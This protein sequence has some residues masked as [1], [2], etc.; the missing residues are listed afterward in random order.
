MKKLFFITG[1]MIMTIQTTTAKLNIPKY[2]NLNYK[3]EHLIPRYID[4]N[5][6]KVY[7][8]SDKTLPIVRITLFI[9]TGKVYEPSDK[10]GIGTLFFEMLREGGSVKFK[11]T[12]IEK[13]LEYLG[14]EINTVINNEDASI[15]MYCH[16]K[17]FDEVFEIFSD[18]IINP[19]FEEEKFNLKKQEI[20]E[21]IKR[22]N[23]DPS[24]QVTREALRMFFGIE[25]PY[26]RR[27]EI[28]TV[29]KITINDLKNF[30]KDFFTS[31]NIIISASGDFDEN[32]MYNKISSSFSKIP[33][34][35]PNIVEIDEP[36]IQSG[37]KIYVIDKRLRQAFIVILHKG[38]KRHDDREFPLSVLMEYMGGGIQSKLG[39]EIR[40]KRGLAYSVYQYFSKRD[41]SGFIMTYL[42]TKPESVGEAIENILNELQKAKNGIIDGKEFEMAKSQLINSFVFRFEN[43][44]SLLNEKAGYDIYSYPDDYLYKYTEKINNVTIDDVKKIANELYDLEN[45]LIFIVGEYNRFKSQLEK[46][47]EI[48]IL[49]ED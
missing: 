26:G 9:K 11:S 4:T 33:S 47:G 34:T 24:K 31:K 17:D 20:I 8:K 12:E 48:K 1:V 15:S 13:K 25:H 49:K 40:S 44:F 37:K 7:I 21:T 38:I 19:A 18:I 30:H 23:D 32:E 35:Q 39:N 2:S 14:A 43:V 6:L 16:K 5:K 22:R 27:P 42:G 29:E 41:K 46:L 45:Y 3:P 28:E 10:V 36:N